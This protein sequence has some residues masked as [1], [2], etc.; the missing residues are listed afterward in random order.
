M[1]IFFNKT[2]RKSYWYLLE[3]IR[4]LKY[5]VGAIWKNTFFP[6][7]PLTS[8][9]SHDDCIQVV[10]LQ[11]SKHLMRA[12]YEI[13]IDTTLVENAA[14]MLWQ[15]THPFFV[16]AAYPGNRGKRHHGWDLFL[17]LFTPP[18]SLPMSPVWGGVLSV[19]WPRRVTKLHK[20]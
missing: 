17:L 3:Q 9:T 16:L 5:G 19:V 14:C 15:S 10:A 13:P 8:L 4:I 7:D 20:S 12:S 1:E 18:P 11:I 2:I 6:P